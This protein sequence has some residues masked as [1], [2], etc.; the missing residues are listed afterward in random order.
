MRIRKILFLGL[1]CIAMNSGFS[2]NPVLHFD[3]VNDMVNLGGD[4][5]NGIRSI[6]LWFKSDS[7]IYPNNPERITLLTRN[8]DNQSG[9][10]GIYIGY[11]FL[12]E[13]GRVTFT[14]QID[15]VFYYIY[16]N[17]NEWVAG[18]WY[19]VAAV[20]DPSLGMLMYIDGVLQ[21]DIDPSVE[22]TG[23]QTEM[24]TIGCWG[25][26]LNRWFEGRI[27]EVRFWNRA[28]T[29]EE[30]NENMC[31]TLDASYTS[32]LTGYWRMDEGEGH[33]VLNYADSTRDADIF[34]CTYVEDTLCIPTKMNETKADAS[35]SIIPNP[36]TDNARIIFPNESKQ[37]GTFKLFDTQG[38]TIDEYEVANTNNIYINRKDIKGGIYF[39]ILQLDQTQFSGKIIFK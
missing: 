26:K 19:H 25:D 4:A 22:P 3:G 33:T 21:Q 27:D 32:G 31:D 18:Q 30:I 11:N 35:V 34:G 5:G 16:S 17:S 36:V 12:G 29:F 24:T 6:E 28:L 1:L 9:E 37:S 23:V 39:Y 38:Q 8:S 13:Q 14:R 15:S 7:S 20:I 10:F 2:Q